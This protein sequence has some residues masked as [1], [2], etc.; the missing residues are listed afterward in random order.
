MLR[1]GLIVN[2]G[3]IGQSC[4]ALS[5]RLSDVGA[6]KTSVARTVQMNPKEFFRLASRLSI[7]L[8]KGDLGKLQTLARSTR[9][10]IVVAFKQQ[11][12][13]SANPLD[14][15]VALAFL[16]RRKTAVAPN[17]KS[18]ILHPFV[19]VS[20]SQSFSKSI[21]PPE[22]IHTTLPVPALPANVHATA[23]APAPSAITRLRS[24]IRRSADATSSNS[25]T[26]ASSINCC[27][28]LSICGKTILAPIPSTKDDW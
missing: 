24:A 17:C 14:Q 27:A 9:A 15:H 1:T 19:S 6:I 8:A 12:S 4:A 3:T 25:A 26:N 21:F 18:S 28:R 11:Q 20:I 16:F 7:G 13:M 23:Q 2:S 22:T 10:A 5:Q